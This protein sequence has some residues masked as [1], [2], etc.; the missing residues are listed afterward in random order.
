M[1][2]EKQ[3]ELSAPKTG[4]KYAA[5]RDAENSQD[6]KPQ[7]FLKTAKKLL[8]LL[9]G[10]RLKVLFVILLS[11]ASAGLGVIGPQYLKSIIDII[12]EQVKNKL[13]TGSMDFSPVTG[14]LKNIAVIFGLYALLL[15]RQLC[16]GKGFAGRYYR[17][18]R[19]S[20]QKNVA[21]ASEL[22]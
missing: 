11:A 22:F 20:E 21:S 4:E 1:K 7:N 10:N 2:K 13:Q 14:V 5:Y 19:Q 6:R 12:S 16:Y 17:T 3:I 9:K 18:A 15:C 8:S